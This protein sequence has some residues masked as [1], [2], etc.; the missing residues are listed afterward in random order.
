MVS[1]KHQLLARLSWAITGACVPGVVVAAPPVLAG[2]SPSAPSAAAPVTIARPGVM[3]GKNWQT[4]MHP[5]AYLISEKLDGVR[6]LWDGRVLRFRSGRVIPAPQW[7]VA[8]FPKTPMDGELWMGRQQF[9]RLSGTVRK[10]VP[11]DQE[12]RAVRYM[13]FDAPAQSGR[14]AARA[15]ELKQTVARANVAWLT[16]VDQ[17]RVAHPDALMQLLHRTASE[18]G[19]GLMLHHADATWKSGRSDDLRKLK[20]VPDEDG[21][22]LAHIPGKGHLQ[23]KMGALLLHTPD[24][25]RFAL[26]TGFTDAQRENPPAVGT[27]V[28]YRYRDRTATGLPKFA[29]FLRERDLD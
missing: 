2:T 14:F 27:L 28:T 20:P 12:W 22:V 19:E 8:G 4:G 13:V 6:A 7:F 29:S 24:G 5:Q 11:I 18:G 25:Q 3:L 23:G 9:D 1:S 26:G 17:Q 10:T 21:T 15:T 16:A